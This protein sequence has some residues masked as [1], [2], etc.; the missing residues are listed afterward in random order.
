MAFFS[1]ESE[2]AEATLEEL[3]TAAKQFKGKVS[4]WRTLQKTSSCRYFL[5]LYHTH[6]HTRAQ[7]LFVQIDTNEESAERIMEF[8]NIKDGDTPT[9]RLINLED[10]MKKYVPDF[11]ELS[12]EKLVQFVE[13]YL[14]GELKVWVCVCVCVRV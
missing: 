1:S 13:S 4:F 3:K 12:A 11:D 2:T 5:S 10:D 7:M 14:A 6:T 8:F 9:S